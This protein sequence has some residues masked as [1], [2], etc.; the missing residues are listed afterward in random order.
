MKAITLASQIINSGDADAIV[1]GGME[2]MS[3]A[4]SS[5]GC[6]LGYRMSMPLA[7]L[8]MSWCMTG[9]MRY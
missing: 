1:A 3:N 2:N 6:P 5:S 8:L 7:R 4:P 9:F